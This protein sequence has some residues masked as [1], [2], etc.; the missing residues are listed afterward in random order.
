VTVHQ[1]V[2]LYAS[3]L[4]AGSELTHGFRDGRSGW[5]QIVRGEVALDGQALSAGDGA[6]IEEVEAVRI[7]ATGEA[8]FL[9][10][11]LR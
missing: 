6:A 2:D 11:D 1:D 9:L 10:F 4:S 3:V 5:L 7:R 8:E